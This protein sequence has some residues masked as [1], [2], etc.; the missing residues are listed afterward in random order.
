M[1]ALSDY[2]RFEASGLWRPSPDEQ[3]LEVI[4]SVG[5]ATL[6][7]TDIRDRALAHWSL[8]AV[9]RANPGRLPAIYHPDGNPGETLELAESE[10]E[11]I[12]A[13]ERL[14]TAIARQ[15]PHPGRL[16]LYLSLISVAALVL[17]GI[18]WFPGAVR[19][20]TIGVIPDVKRGE[21]GQALVALLRGVTGPPCQEPD[22]TRALA[23]L[24]ERLQPDGGRMRLIVVREGVPGAIP[25]LGDTILIN[26]RLVEDFEEPDVVAGH[27]IA[28]QVRAR[29]EDPLDA[30]L[31]H[32]GIWASLRL[33]ATGQLTDDL[34]R[35]HA[36]NLMTA[37]L[38]AIAD[39]TLLAGFEAA[40]VRATPYAYAQDSTGETTL[41]LIEADPHAAQPT[42][43]VISDADWLRLQGICAG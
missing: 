36:E 16:R 6:T 32:G 43:P 13:V 25:L 37:P 21:I 20:H 42:A 3:R 38:P 2:Q 22:G 5:D 10:G 28:A 9:T 35:S 4:V 33:L 24:A 41:G 11:F 18:F 12:S 14:R 26:K 29:L 8:P 31:R 17:L 23:R 27:V 1:T 7:I 34:L 40:G 30:L 15:R 39:D 19:N